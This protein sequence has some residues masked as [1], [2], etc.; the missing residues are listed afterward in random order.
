LAE[1]ANRQSGQVESLVI[2]C[3]FNSHLGYSEGLLV[4][5]ATFLI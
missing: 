1:N 3:G 2:V 5:A 4:Q